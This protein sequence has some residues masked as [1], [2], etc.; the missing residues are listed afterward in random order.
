MSHTAMYAYEGADM[1]CAGCMYVAYEDLDM[2][3]VGQRHAGHVGDSRL[4]RLFE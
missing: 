1:L 3:G 2:L 4:D